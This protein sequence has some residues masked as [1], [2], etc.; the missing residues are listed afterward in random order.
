MMK[1]QSLAMWGASA[2]TPAKLSGLYQM[3]NNQA[4]AMAQNRGR[5]SSEFVGSGTK[6][7]RPLGLSPS[8]WPPLQQAQSQQNGSGMR[9]VF[10]GNQAG[11]R[12]CAGTGVFLPRQV[13]AQTETRRK[14]GTKTKRRRFIVIVLQLFH[15]MKSF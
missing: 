11:K 8:A 13:G 7:S 15:L 5:N 3:N 6:T 2:T 14:P 12:E 10:L 1:Q 9:A 4:Q